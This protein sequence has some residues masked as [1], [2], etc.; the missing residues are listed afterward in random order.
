M[1]A[2]EL[3]RRVD[4]DVGPVL[5]GAQQIGRREGAVDDQ[6]DAVGVGDG[7]NGFEV[8]DIGIGVAQALGVE[9]LRVRADGLLE[10]LGVRR[11]T[12][13]VSRPCSRRVLAI[14]LNVPP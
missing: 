8:N 13:V 14:R 5:D 1:A 2:D 10:I 6:G 11:S 12:K 3:R 4:N 7:S 9:Q